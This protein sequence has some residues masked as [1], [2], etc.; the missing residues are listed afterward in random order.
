MSETLTQTDRSG[1]ILLEKEGKYLCSWLMLGP[2]KGNAIWWQSEILNL[3]NPDF[4]R[5]HLASQAHCA[6]T[7]RLH[8]RNRLL[9]T[10]S[11]GLIVAAAII[12]V[13]AVR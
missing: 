2:G 9:T 5:Q 6:E 3:M 10:L 12:T 1:K 4:A 7:I 8:R 13:V 11:V